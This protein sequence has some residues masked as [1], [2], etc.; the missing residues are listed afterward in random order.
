MLDAGAHRRVAISTQQMD[1]GRAINQNQGLT[2][3]PLALQFID[4]NEFLAGARVTQQ[5]SHALALIKV[6]QCSDHGFSFGA[7][8]G[9]AHCILKVFLRNINRRFHASIL[10]GK[11]TLVALELCDPARISLF[12]N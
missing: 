11:C 8:F 6:L 2:L 1:P 5:C 4:R 3:V 10:H 9:E 7:C 12:R